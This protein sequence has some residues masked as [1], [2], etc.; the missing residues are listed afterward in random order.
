VHYVG[1]LR[2][3]YHRHRLTSDIGIFIRID[4]FLPKVRSDEEWQILPETSWICIPDFSVVWDQVLVERNALCSVGTSLA[5]RFRLN[6][7]RITTVR[8]L[9][10]NCMSGPNPI[11]LHVF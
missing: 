10:A 1:N 11:V 9:S 7:G 8:S 5:R 2:K 6:H 4:L 3:V